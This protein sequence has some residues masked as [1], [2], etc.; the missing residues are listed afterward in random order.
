MPLPTF[1]QT[2][3]RRDRGIEF[4][5]LLRERIA[6]WAKGFIVV[7][8]FQFRSIAVDGG[9]VPGATAQRGQATWAGHPIRA[10][11]PE[12]PACA[13]DGVCS[14]QL[15]GRRPDIHRRIVENQVLDMDELP[16]Q[17]H[18][19]SRVEEVSPLDE[20]LPERAPGHALVEPREPV[21]GP[22]DGRNQLFRVIVP[23]RVSH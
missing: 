16:R 19:R 3:R 18:T 14:G 10:I 8:R 21:L 1:Q 12:P 5:E 15:M 4:R 22:P 20:A 13:E 9:V 23:R 2:V 6:R 7:V 11:A 17:P